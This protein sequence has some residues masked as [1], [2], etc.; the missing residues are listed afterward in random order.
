VAC[1]GEGFVCWLSS[2][3][4]VVVVVLV[5]VQWHYA[6]I[7]VVAV[8]LLRSENPVSSQIEK[9][10]SDSS[11]H[12]S[13]RQAARIHPRGSRIPSRRSMVSAPQCEVQARAATVASGA[14]GDNLITRV[15][16]HVNVLKLK[17]L[18]SRWAAQ[19]RDLLHFARGPDRHRELA[20]PLHHDQA[21]RLNRI[22]ATSTRGVRACICRVA[23]WATPTGSAG[24]AGATANLK[25][26]FHLDHSAGADH[27]RQLGPCDNFAARARRFL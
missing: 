26:T 10:I 21:P 23:G 25:L 7:I 14:A 27:Q 18:A 9:L 15:W 8:P 3:V 4:L 1:G 13:V 22:Q 19:R 17:G 6:R 20:T 2:T 12:L 24:H 11:G 5:L 16:I